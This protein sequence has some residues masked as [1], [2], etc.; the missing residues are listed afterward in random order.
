MVVSI[1]FDLL[2]SALST[3]NSQLYRSIKARYGGLT[4]LLAKFPHRFILA[5]DPPFNHV[6][7]IGNSVRSPEHLKLTNRGL[8]AITPKRMET[9]TSAEA[10]EEQVVK[11]TE[12]ILSSA[13]EKKLK[14]VALANML[15]ESLGTEVF[16]FVDV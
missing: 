9:K 4:P 13:P 15:R 12:R 1:Y 2:G 7:V 6:S 10:V 8:G 11:E 5:K 14:A 3:S 16:I